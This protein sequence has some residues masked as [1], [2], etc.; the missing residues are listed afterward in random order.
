LHPLGDSRASAMMRSSARVLVSTGDST[1]IVF[2]PG[3][4][5]GPGR[6]SAR[7][8]LRVRAICRRWSRPTWLP[9]HM[10]TAYAQLPSRCRRRRPARRPTRLVG[11]GEP[12]AEALKSGIRILGGDRRLRRPRPAPRERHPGRSV[13]LKKRRTEPHPGLFVAPMFVGIRPR[14][15]EHGLFREV[16]PSE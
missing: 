13:P 11:A 4:P 5:A 15:T 7:S 14:T 16:R 9:Q 2:G 6:P 8:I 12:A 3:S 1:E 10:L